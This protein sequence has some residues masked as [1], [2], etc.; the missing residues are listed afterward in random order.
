MGQLIIEGNNRQ[1]NIIVKENRIRAVKHGLKI[2][3]EDDEPKKATTVAPTAKELIGL[4]Q[5]CE[6]VE[7]LNEFSSDDRKTVI[8]AYNVR[9]E[10]LQSVDN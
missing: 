5:A 4:I 8:D 2:S 10:E 9:L 7:A 6:T 1:L 3:I